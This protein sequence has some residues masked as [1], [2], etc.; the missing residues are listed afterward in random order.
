M[1]YEAKLGAKSTLEK[2]K[3]I[4]APNSVLALKKHFECLGAQIETVGIVHSL[5]D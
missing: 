2:G 5:D 3:T 4:T 1:S